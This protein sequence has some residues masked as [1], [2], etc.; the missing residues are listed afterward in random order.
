MRHSFE[1]K[2]ILNKV[3]FP[4]LHDVPKLV[5][6]VLSYEKTLAS[7][8][9]DRAKRLAEIESKKFQDMIEAIGRETLISMAK[10][11]DLI[12]IFCIFHAIYLG[13]T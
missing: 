13:W 9:I 4:C 6:A 1:S 11:R 10:V 5:L 8:E 3:S 12:S 7:L 2:W